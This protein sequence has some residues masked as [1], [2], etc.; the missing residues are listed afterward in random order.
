MYSRS[1][2]DPSNTS[3]MTRVT[4]SPNFWRRTK[5][6]LKRKCFISR[7][8]ASRLSSVLPPLIFETISLILPPT[9]LLC[10]MFIFYDSFRQLRHDYIP[11]FCSLC[12]F[13]L[14][15]CWFFSKELLKQLK[16]I[17]W[18]HRCHL[19]DGSLLCTT[20]LSISMCQEIVISFSTEVTI[21]EY[22]QPSTHWHR[23]SFSPPFSFSQFWASNCSLVYIHREQVLDQRC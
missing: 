5:Q 23:F 21:W 6:N 12:S 13:A 4:L 10:F 14:V 9:I 18:L 8:Y 22:P 7:V 3:Q 2:C 11:Y 17:A 1:S 19:S 20:S 15:V 16:S